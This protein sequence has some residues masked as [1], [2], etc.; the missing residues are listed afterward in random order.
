MKYYDNIL[1]NPN[2]L[3]A[4]CDKANLKYCDKYFNKARAR[5]TSNQHYSYIKYC[6][7]HFNQPTLSIHKVLWQALYKHDFATTPIQFD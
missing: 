5:V 6:D 3:W 2:N 7:K 1:S 4:A